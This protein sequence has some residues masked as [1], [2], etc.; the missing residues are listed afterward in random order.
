[1]N[2]VPNTNRSMFEGLS[3]KSEAVIT[4]REYAE[5]P[6]VLDMTFNSIPSDDEL[7]VIITKQIEELQENKE[8]ADLT[9]LP[10][11]VLLAFS[12]IDHVR[13]MMKG[14][15]GTEIPAD[16]KPKFN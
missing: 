6:G 14:R 15:V 7:A 11:P 13:E 8:Q 12:A 5:M 4:I 16:M 1:M 9:M 10:M 3:V 2:V